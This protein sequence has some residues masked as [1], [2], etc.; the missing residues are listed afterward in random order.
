MAGSRDFVATETLKN[1]VAVTIRALRVDDRARVAAAVRQLDAE[2]VYS[3]LFTQRR[4]LTETGLT[5][6]MSVDPEREVAL[7]VT[8]GAD[9]RI[10]ASARYVVTAAGAS[11]RTAEVAFLVAKDHQGLGLA[12]RLLAHLTN[13]AR[14][15][16]I[17]AFEA[18]VLAG[19][20]P[21]LAVFARSGLPM[22][23]QRDGGVV[24]LTLALDA[25]RT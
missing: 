23:Q 8:A 2:S 18:D 4:E 24:H 22:R 16:D 12:G 11:G 14:E 25:A 17:A 7:V 20:G 19:N 21:M 5:R 6:I 10:V 15:D 9:E 13:L 1:G 3:R